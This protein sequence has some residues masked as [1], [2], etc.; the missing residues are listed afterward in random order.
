MIKHI[1]SFKLKPEYKDKAPQI[2]QALDSLPEKI[3]QIKYFQIGINISTAPSAYDLVLVSG[4]DSVED[5][6]IYRKHPEHVKVVEF[7]ALYKAES[8][9]VDYIK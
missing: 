1:V 5:L 9:V 2:K 8:M 6:D 4:F 7:I 3:F